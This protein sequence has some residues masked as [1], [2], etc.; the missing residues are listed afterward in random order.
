MCGCFHS[1]HIDHCWEGGYNLNLLPFSAFTFALLY[2][3]LRLVLLWKTKSLELKEQASG[4]PVVFSLSGWWGRLYWL[5]YVGFYLNLVF[6]AL[7]TWHFLTQQ[8]PIPQGVT[9]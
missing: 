9:G 6:I 8:V 2:N 3:I 7:H 1:R 4:L 5:S